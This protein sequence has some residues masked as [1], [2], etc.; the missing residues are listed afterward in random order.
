MKKKLKEE[1][2]KGPP[3]LFMMESFNFGDQQPRPCNW[4]G[5]EQP[6]QTPVNDG[7]FN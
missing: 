6:R 1:M 7:N 2:Q 5:R 4:N 3:V